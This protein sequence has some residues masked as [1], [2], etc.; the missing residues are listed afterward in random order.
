MLTLGL[1]S[2]LLEIPYDAYTT[3]SQTDWLFNTQPRVLQADWFIL[4]V[5]EKATLDIFVFYC[6]TV[7]YVYLVDKT[8]CAR[9]WSRFKSKNKNQNAHGSIN[10]VG[11]LYTNIPSN[12]ERVLIVSKYFIQRRTSAMCSKQS[13]T[14]WQTGRAAHVWRFQRE[15]P[16]HTT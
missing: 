3:L 10:Q 14:P 11:T 5:K 7:A 16:R 9:N 6:E 8:I 2:Y 15:Q 1:S 4:E 13:V 12:L